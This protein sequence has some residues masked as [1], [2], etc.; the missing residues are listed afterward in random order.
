MVCLALSMQQILEQYDRPLALSREPTQLMNTTV[1]GTAPSD[2]RR[3]S[4]P[5]GPDA[6]TSRSNCSELITSG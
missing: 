6:E 5:V 3:S 4:P 1:L 2:G